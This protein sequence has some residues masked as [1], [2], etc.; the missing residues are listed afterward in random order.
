MQWPFGHDVHEAVAPLRGENPTFDISL[1][2]W[3]AG[4]ILP[5]ATYPLALISPVY[6]LSRTLKA[7]APTRVVN[8]RQ[9]NYGIVFPRA[10]Y[11]HARSVVGKVLAPLSLFEATDRF[12]VRCLGGW[13]G[14]CP[15]SEESLLESTFGLLISVTARPPTFP[16]VG[17]EDVDNSA[18]EQDHHL[19]GAAYPETDSSSWTPLAAPPEL[20]NPRIR[21]SNPISLQSVHL[22]KAGDMGADTEESTNRAPT[23]NVSL[24]CHLSHTDTAATFTLTTNSVFIAAPPCRGTHRVNP[25]KASHYTFIVR[26][27]EDLERLPNWGEQNGDGPAILVINA[28]GGPESEVFARAWCCHTGCNA[29]VWRADGEKS[30]CFKCALMVA[31]G[32]GL[33][34]RVLTV[35]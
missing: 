25:D 5:G 10:S 23:Y 11:W 21:D 2:D 19:K 24:D 20:L 14:P 18:R 26:G 7:H 32:E 30:C 34:T 9:G 35:C 12:R 17:S 31:S 28:R 4:F 16:E 8:A 13:I 6:N 29:V 27:V 15:L 3:M 22:T 33:G 1:M